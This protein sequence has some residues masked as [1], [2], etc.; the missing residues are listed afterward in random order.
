M[1]FLELLFTGARVCD[2]QQLHLQ[3]NGSEN[4]NV[5]DFGRAAAHRAA[6]HISIMPLPEFTARKN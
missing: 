2:P 6:L 3:E 4:L 1:E 5:Q